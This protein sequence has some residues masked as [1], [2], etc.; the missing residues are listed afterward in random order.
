MDNEWYNDSVAWHHVH[1]V[2]EHRS[3]AAG[4]RARR[5]AV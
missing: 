1:I 2:N 4:N 3:V 5:D